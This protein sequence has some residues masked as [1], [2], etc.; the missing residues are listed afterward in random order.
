MRPHSDRKLL[1]VLKSIE[2]L[3]DTQYQLQR[4]V[5]QVTLDFQFSKRCRDRFNGILQ[6]CL[7]WV[8]TLI[9]PWQGFTCSF[10]LKLKRGE[11]AYR[12]LDRKNFPITSNSWG[13]VVL[14]GMAW[15]PKALRQR[16]SKQALQIKAAHSPRSHE[17][18]VLRCFWMCTRPD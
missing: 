14:D 8:K 18:G 11:A 6:G 17:L 7:S 12:Q 1:H 9:W 15:S 5:S 3:S 10:F 4:Q 2:R 13:Q 16:K